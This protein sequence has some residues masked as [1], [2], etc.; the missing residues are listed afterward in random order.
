[1]GCDECEIR[2]ESAR[3]GAHMIGPEARGRRIWSAG[4][5]KTETMK[6]ACCV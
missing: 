4:R 5:S 6:G 1:M 3:G 2:E